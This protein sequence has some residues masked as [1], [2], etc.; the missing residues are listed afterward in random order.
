MEKD[1]IICLF[2]IFFIMTFWAFIFTWQQIGFL[3]KDND[4]FNRMLIEF[5]INKKYWNMDK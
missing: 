1:L 2:V 4:K 3:K 5:E